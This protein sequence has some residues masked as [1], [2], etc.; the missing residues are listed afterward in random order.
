[1]GVSAQE[2]LLA[3]Q[4]S[5]VVDTLHELEDAI[6]GI[7]REGS[8]KQAEAYLKAERQQVFSSEVEAEL[9]QGNGSPSMIASIPVS[10][11][12]QLVCVASSAVEPIDELLHGPQGHPRFERLFDPRLQEPSVVHRL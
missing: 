11:S 5:V 2:E 9:S 6:Y 3:L 8:E 12:A 7:Q 1:V 10:L 4:D